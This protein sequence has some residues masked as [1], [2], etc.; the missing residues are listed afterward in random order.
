MK[1]A[2]QIA[3]AVTIFQI[4]E[5]SLPFFFF[6]VFYFPVEKNINRALKTEIDDRKHWNLFETLGSMRMQVVVFDSKSNSAN[7]Y[8]I[9]APENSD[10]NES[11]A[12]FLI[13]ILQYLETP[14]YL[15]KALFPRHSSLRFVVIIFIFIFEE[16]EKT[17]K[18]VF[19]F[20]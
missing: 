20:G 5:V 2:G 10:D 12:A 17:A 9:A 6:L 19:F 8:G 13:R 7:S 11:G 18:L 16:G 4:D 3:R 14:Q 15:R 1:L